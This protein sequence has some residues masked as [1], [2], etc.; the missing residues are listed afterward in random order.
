MTEHVAERHSRL[1]LS[2]RDAI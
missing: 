1:E 2:V